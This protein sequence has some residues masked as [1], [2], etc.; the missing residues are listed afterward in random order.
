V[1]LFVVVDS[2]EDSV[3]RTGDGAVNS[4]YMPQK[5]PPGS[6]RLDL[7]PEEMETLMKALDLYEAYLKSQQRGNAGCR[8]LSERLRGAA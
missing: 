6:V 2:A 7:S 5:K 8:E 1:D 3:N 4:G